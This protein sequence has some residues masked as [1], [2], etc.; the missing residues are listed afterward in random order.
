MEISIRIYNTDSGIGIY[1]GSHDSYHEFAPL[2]DK[3]I[4]KYHGHGPNALHESKMSI[5]GM[6]CPTIPLVG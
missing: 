3:V 1:A 4:E 5:D 2:M 6:V